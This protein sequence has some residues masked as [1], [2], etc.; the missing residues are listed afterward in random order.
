[1]M[2]L[3]LRCDRGA[4]FSDFRTVSTFAHDYDKGTILLLPLVGVRGPNI[5]LWDL[6]WGHFRNNE[7]KNAVFYLERESR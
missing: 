2:E 4:V 3:A 1:M 6:S 5:Q 7:Q